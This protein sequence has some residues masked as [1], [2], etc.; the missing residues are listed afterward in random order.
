MASVSQLSR[1]AVSDSAP[2]W[3]A[4]G[5]ASLSITN[6]RSLLKL[7]SIQLVMPS[8]HLITL[9]C[10]LLLLPSTFASIRVFSNESGLHIR[11][12]KYW[13]FSFSISPSNEYSGL[14]SFRMDCCPLICCPRNSQ[15]PSPV[16][17]FRSINSFMFSLLY[18]P[19]LT[20]VQESWKN[21]SFN[22]MD[23]CRQ[24]DV[25]AF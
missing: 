18:S 2:P 19:T 23:L 8:D 17:Q 11:Q 21:H 5:Q 24:S 7:M 15:E 13:R 25:S 12:P 16:L 9:C 22:Y 14:I 3:T 6:S 1:S 20:S 10:P 4:A